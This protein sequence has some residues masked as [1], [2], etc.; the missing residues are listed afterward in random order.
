MKKIAVIGMVGNSAFLPVSRF[1][2]GGE[3]VIAHSVYFEPGGKGYN[4]AVAAARCGASVSFLGAVGTD[5]YESIRDFSR[6]EGMDAMLPKKEGQTAYAAILTD[7]QGN[8][9]VT[10]YQ[11]PSLTE[12]DVEAFRSRIA[13]ADLLLL[14]NEV[15]ETVNCKAAQIAKEKGVRVLLNPAPGRVLSE[16]LI[17]L[18]DLFTP[19]EYEAEYLPDQQNL[20]ITLGSRGAFLKERGIT[21]PVF[22]AGQAVDTTGAGDTFTGVLAVMLAEGKDLE[23]AARIASVASGIGVTRRYAATSIPTRE[24][25]RQYINL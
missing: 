4:Q 7:A 12:A 10:V 23:E 17:A 14:N 8:N 25:I 16:K 11:G 15:P 22:S 9:H 2:Q 1:H 13:Q 5:G 6:Q 20:V 24:E 21:V 3:T 19:N 18:T